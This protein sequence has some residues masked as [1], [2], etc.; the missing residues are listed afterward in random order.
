MNR[1]Q[2]LGRLTRDVEIRYSQGEK[3]TAIA[4]S[5][6]AVQRTFKNADGGYDA[7]FINL[8]A[9]GRT[10]EFMEKYFRKG[11]PIAVTGEIRTGSYTNKDGNKVYTTDV[12]VTDVE[13]VPQ[14]KGSK[15]SSGGEK[16]TGNEDFMNI[17]EGIE[18]LPFN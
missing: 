8:V 1:V 4:R 12:N 15:S 10:A 2:L 14:D 11:S 13:F 7:D 6:I 9:F 17:P 18:E 5:S 3:A 16:A